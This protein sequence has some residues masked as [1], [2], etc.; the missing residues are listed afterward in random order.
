MCN[1]RHNMGV[2]YVSVCAKQIHFCDTFDTGATKVMNLQAMPRN[3]SL[4]SCASTSIEGVAPGN[5]DPAYGDIDLTAGTGLT[6]GYRKARI[7][8]AIGAL[9]G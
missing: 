8:I 4:L 6:K 2:S 5:C 3:S 9:T 7:R 1:M